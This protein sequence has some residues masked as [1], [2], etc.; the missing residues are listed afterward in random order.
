[1]EGATRNLIPVCKSFPGELTRSVF[2]FHGL[3]KRSCNNQQR[4][5][6]KWLGW[7][8]RGRLERR[9]FSAHHIYTYTFIQGQY[10]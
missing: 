1:M 2:L 9:A 5:N 4:T 3:T 8:A 10:E 6:V 7:R